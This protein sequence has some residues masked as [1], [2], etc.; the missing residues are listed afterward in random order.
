[1]FRLK[2]CLRC[3][4]D[5]FLEK[6]H[7]GSYV[8]CL[9]CGSVTYPEEAKATRKST[10]GNLGASFRLTV[11]SSLLP[12]HQEREHLASTTESAHAVN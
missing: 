2:S 8:V 11:L 9:N 12:Q 5:C 6:D 10:T 4:G 1:M 7:Y 3:D